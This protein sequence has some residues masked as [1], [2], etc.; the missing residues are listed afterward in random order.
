MSLGLFV[1]FALILATFVCLTGNLAAQ[2]GCDF[3]GIEPGTLRGLALQHA[4]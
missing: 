1:R 4:L 3:L 2:R